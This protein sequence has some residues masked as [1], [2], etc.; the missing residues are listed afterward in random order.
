MKYDYLTPCSPGDPAAMEMTWND[1]QSN[2]LFEPP[3][4]F[5]DFEK[6]L[7]F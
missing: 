2:N 1:V 4:T 5:R 3:V 6:S 7:R